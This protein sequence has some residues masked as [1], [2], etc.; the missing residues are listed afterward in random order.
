MRRAFRILTASTLLLFSA[1]CFAQ[2]SIEGLWKYDGFF[3]QEHRFENPNPDLHLYFTFFANGRHRLEWWRENDQEY[4]E[5]TGSMELKDSNLTLT[6]E[7]LNPKNHANCGKDPD[8]RLNRVTT[9]P[10]EF[11]GD[12]LW[13]QLEID[14]KPFFYIVKRIR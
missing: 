14:G 4:C 9:S 6:T 7:W 5:R 3:Y 2:E 10:V 13:M 8:M 12:E 1:L 11:K